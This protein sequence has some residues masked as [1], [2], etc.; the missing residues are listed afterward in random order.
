MCGFGN[1]GDAVS[2]DFGDE[3]STSKQDG[4]DQLQWVF[5]FQP[6]AALPRKG[7]LVLSG[8]PSKSTEDT[9]HLAPKTVQGLVFFVMYYL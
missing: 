9:I 3:R 5:F 2:C 4:A 6:F 7:L 1:E 8:S